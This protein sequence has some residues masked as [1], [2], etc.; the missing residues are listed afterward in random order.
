MIRRLWVN[1]PSWEDSDPMLR[2]LTEDGIVPKS[3][4]PLEDGIAR[5][6]REHA[7][8][9]QEYTQDNFGIEDQNPR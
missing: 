5:H 3:K 6:W 2:P 1:G 7:D 8:N 9:E 4:K